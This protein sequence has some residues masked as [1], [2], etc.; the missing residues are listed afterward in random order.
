M[1]NKDEPPLHK[2]KKKEEIKR[3]EGEKKAYVSPFEGIEM[4]G[5]FRVSLL[6]M[7]GIL[8]QSALCSDSGKDQ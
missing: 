1:L 2:S 6:L 7:G 5:N 3:K 4:K 8:S